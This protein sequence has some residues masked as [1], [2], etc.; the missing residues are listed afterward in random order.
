[1]VSE[2]VFNPAVPAETLLSESYPGSWLADLSLSVYGR[3]VLGL[4]EI[5]WWVGTV[6]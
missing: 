2:A 4:N 5:M 3:K 1:M 6:C